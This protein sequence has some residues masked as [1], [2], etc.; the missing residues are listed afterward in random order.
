MKAQAQPQLNLMPWPS[1][2]EVGSGQ[3]R[4]DESFSISQDIH[5]YGDPRLSGA[6]NR[7]LRQLSRQTGIPLRPIDA[8]NSARATFSVSIQH[9]SKDVDELGEDESYVL[10]I[11]PSAGV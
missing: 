1:N 9:P 3:L 2:V 8:P 6:V 10:Q 7:F 5:G 4:I 11:A